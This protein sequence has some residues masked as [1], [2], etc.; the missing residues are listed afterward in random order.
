[1]PEN[2]QPMTPFERLFL[3]PPEQRDPEIWALRPKQWDPQMYRKR[4]AYQWLIDKASGKIY[5]PACAWDALAGSG[6]TV[7]GAGAKLTTSRKL[8]GDEPQCVH[9]GKRLIVA[10]KTPRPRKRRRSGLE[11][12]TNGFLRELARMIRA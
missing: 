5:C 11:R 9:C 2:D 8:L 1:M 10:V 4:N 6:W 7:E 12:A 3:I